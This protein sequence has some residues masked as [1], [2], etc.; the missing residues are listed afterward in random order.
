MALNITLN[1][2]NLIG[3]NNNTF[4][5]NFIQGSIVIP[6]K[7]SIS[8]N[9]IIVPYSWRNI[10]ATLGNNTYSYVMPSG[11][12]GTTTYGPYTIPD[13]FY[14]VSDLNALIQAQFRTNGHYWY[15]YS[16]TS[17]QNGNTYFYPLTITTTSSL[18]AN[19]ITAYNIPLAASIASI[20]GTGAARGDGSN[21]T[22]NWSGTYPTYSGACCQLVL[23]GSNQT[24]KTTYL[25]NLLGFIPASYPTTATG[26]TTLTSSTNGNTLTQSPPYPALGSIVNGVIVRCNLVDNNVASPSDVLACIP[27][28]A[29]Y[30]SN[31]NY[32]PLSDFGVKMKQGRFSNLTITF[33]DQN[34]NQLLALDPNVLINLSIKF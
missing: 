10:T 9:Q 30:G 21:G 24:A 14:T 1:S 19:T 5:Y 3:I 33:N 23:S 31:I 13:G 7:A 11:A 16:A 4:Q 17:G 2:S 25:G 32:Q 29:T 27:I 12:S 6:D 18:Y 28:T 15:I 8:V 20:F 22:T 34:F 26:L